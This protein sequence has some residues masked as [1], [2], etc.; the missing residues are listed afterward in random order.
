M[1][2]D[3]DIILRVNKAAKGDLTSICELVEYYILTD[4]C[5]W[6]L[7]YQEQL[8]DYHPSIV[9]S[10]YLEATGTPIKYEHFLELMGKNCF[11]QYEDI[12]G[13]RWYQKYL[14]YLDFKNAVLPYKEKMRLK[15]ETE[16]FQ[17][18]KNANELDKMHNRFMLKWEHDLFYSQGAR[19]TFFSSKLSEQNS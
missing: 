7:N 3:F 10:K 15:E 5:Y 18:M 13:Y 8:V 16:I 6:A 1:R 12:K 17:I 9:E 14:D 11:N 4:D 2:V 19:W